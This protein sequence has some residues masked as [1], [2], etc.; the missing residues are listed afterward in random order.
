MI[1]LPPLLG[2]VEGQ[3]TENAPIRPLRNA[4]RVRC[5]CP[6]PSELADGFESVAVRFRG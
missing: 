2:R 4:F 6:L 3:R 5:A 1:G